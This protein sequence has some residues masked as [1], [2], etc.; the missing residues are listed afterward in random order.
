MF[1][2]CLYVAKR[3][4]CKGCFCGK[5]TNDN[6][7]LCNI[8]LTHTSVQR[9]LGKSALLNELCISQNVCLVA[10]CL[11]HLP[12]TQLQLNNQ[13][14]TC[15][16]SCDAKSRS[17]TNLILASPKYFPEVF[18]YDFI[19]DPGVYDS[20]L[21]SILYKMFLIKLHIEPSVE[22]FPAL[23]D[24]LPRFLMPGRYLTD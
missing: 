20:V 23:K 19:N 16:K 11:Q 22:E 21:H 17:I 5:R 24:I 18:N 7:G 3:G 14:K 2:N 12:L 9:G 8:H 13:L 6:N 15:L 4:N 10:E 1:P